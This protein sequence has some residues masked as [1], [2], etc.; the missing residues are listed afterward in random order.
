MP[1]AQTSFFGWVV[2]L[3][4]KYGTLFLRGTGMT[5]LVAL[6][7]TIIGF[8]IG[9]LV[10][11]VRTT[12]PPRSRG[13]RCK[14]GAEKALLAVQRASSGRSSCCSTSTSRSSAVRR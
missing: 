3:L 5:L 1:N 8:V 7:G 9:L 13:I 12:E 10:A 6:T 11:I 14:N 4:E 2:F